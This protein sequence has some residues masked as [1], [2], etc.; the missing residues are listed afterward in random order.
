MFKKK[1]K[2]AASPASQDVTVINKGTVIDGEVR[3]DG[4]IRIYGQLNGTVRS[5]GKVIVAEGGRL[6]GELYATTAVITP[7]PPQHGD[8]GRQCGGGNLHDRDGRYIYWGLSN[9]AKR[10][11]ACRGHGGTGRG[12]GTGE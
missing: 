5:E 3:V 11:L 6:A 1:Q 10:P 8:R 2:Q 9:A 4:T 12:G 7:R